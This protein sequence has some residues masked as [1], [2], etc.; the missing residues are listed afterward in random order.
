MLASGFT[1]RFGATIW[2]RATLTVLVVMAICLTG[3]VSAAESE[4]LRGIN[5]NGSAVTIDGHE[6]E[7]KDAKSLQCDDNAFENTSVTLVPAVDDARAA[8]IRSSRWGGNDVTVTDLPKGRVTVFLYVWEDNDPETFSISVNDRIVVPRFVSGSAGS[9]SRLGPW[10]VD[11]KRGRL[12]IISKGGAANFSGIEIWRGDRTDEPVKLSADDEVLFESKIR[13]L[14]VAHCYDCHSQESG[15]AEGELYLDTREGIRRGGVSGPAI[16]TRELRDS[17]L[18]TAVHYEDSNRQMPPDEKL[19]DN[20]IHDLEQ[21]VSRG[22]PDPRDGK[23]PIKTI[24]FDKGRQFWS[25]QPAIKS[26][27]PVV[28]DDAWPAS[29]IDRFLLAKME[30]DHIQPNPVTDKRTLLRRATIDLT[31]LPPTVEDINHF[32]ADTSP[33]AFEHVLDRLLA[34]QQYGERWG[35]HWMD[36]VRYADTAGDN[37]DFPVPELYLYRNYIIDSIN[38]DKPYDEFVREQIAGD[39]MTSNSDAQRNERLIATGYIAI[40]RR[41]GSLLKNY[42][43]HLTIEDT[44]DNVGRSFLG[45]SV[46]CARCHDHKFDPI[47]KEDYYGLYGMFASTEYPFPGIELEPKP[48]GFVP[49]WENGKPGTKLIYAVHEGDGADVAVQLR[50]DPSQAG[51]IAP[52]KFLSVLGGQ[53][54]PERAQAASGR[55]QLAEWISDPSNPLTARVIVNRVWQ[56]HFGA[57][58]VDT[59]S[60]FGIRGTP[61]THPELLDFLAA[62]FVEQGWSLKKLHKRIMLSKAYQLSSDDDA[63]RL[64]IDPNNHHLWKYPRQRLDAETLRDSLL[65][66]SGE[67]DP[68]MM[69]EPHPFPPP[70]NRKFTQHYPF[71][72]SYESHRRSVYLMGARLN[73]I[74]FFTTFDGADHNATTPSRDSSV[75]AV[76]SLYLL[77]DEFVHRQAAAYAERLIRDEGD[78]DRRLML[79]AVEMTG[80]PLAE[81]DAVTT[82]AFLDRYQESLKTAGVPEEDLERQAWAA[83]LRSLFRTNAFLYL[84]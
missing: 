39:L 14:L 58:L 37:S 64:V 74:P 47:S 59:P 4:F 72:E 13:P 53:T 29:D 18:L 68:S 22:A 62:T 16:D 2:S 25:F 17:L 6:W 30:Q 71:R 77:N 11:V 45:L 24:D 61:P 31:G 23:P 15:T 81:D 9:W 49:L 51:E 57:G 44:I 34:S 7:G 52:R 48:S 40:S 84:D 82:L 75:T 69:N 21:W 3:S 55:K 60:D 56:H 42:P 67:L 33:E 76:Q 66:L 27:V 63:E 43:T 12:R 70:E 78:R 36:L 19:T 20:Q 8:M 41:F 26:A 83:L 1:S 32:L 50:G 73:A 46:S 35:R 54:L 38:S 79:A 5:L 10:P 28:N 65:F 80:K